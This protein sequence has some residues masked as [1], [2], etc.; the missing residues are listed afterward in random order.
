MLYTKVTVKAH[1]DIHS[2]LLLK[3]FLVNNLWLY[4][5][6]FFFNVN[7]CDCNR[8][9]HVILYNRSEHISEGRCFKSEVTHLVAWGAQWRS[10]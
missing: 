6:K 2:A 7:F 8:F 3:Y 9:I 4:T 10:G 5:M 1:V